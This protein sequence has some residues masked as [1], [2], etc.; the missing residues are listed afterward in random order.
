[1]DAKALEAVGILLVEARV[2]LE[3]LVESKEAKSSQDGTFAMLWLALLQVDE[4]E[5]RVARVAGVEG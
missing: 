1:M 5:E 2:L 3:D 4:A